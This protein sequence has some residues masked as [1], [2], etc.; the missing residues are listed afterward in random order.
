V[1]NLFEKLRVKNNEIYITG[2]KFTSRDRTFE[3]SRVNFL[4]YIKEKFGTGISLQEIDNLERFKFEVFLGLPLFLF[5]CG[6]HLRARLVVLVV[7]L[8]RVRPIHL[9]WHCRISTSA[10][11]C[12]VCCHSS[13]FPNVVRPA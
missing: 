10:G 9:Q 11:L 3:R 13:L 7:S 5:P 1:N 12:F 8:R 4:S 6:F 2:P